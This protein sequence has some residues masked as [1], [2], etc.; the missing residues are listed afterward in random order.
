MRRISNILI[1]AIAAFL[2]ATFL[3]SCSA[4]PGIS[5]P[6]P[7]TSG[8]VSYEQ[9]TSEDNL[10]PALELD[11]TLAYVE[12]NSNRPYFGEENYATPIGT[13]VYSPLDSLGRT[14]QAFAL[15]SQDTM[16]AIA[17]ERGDIS[18]VY[19]SGWCQAQY[20]FVDQGWLYNRCH[21]IGWQLTAEN[22][23]AQNLMSGT[24]FLNIQGMLPFENTVAEHV[25]TT[26]HAVLYRVTPAYIGANLLASGV[27][28]EA[29]CTNCSD[30]RFAVYCP[31]VQPGVTIDYATGES[32]V[33]ESASEAVVDAVTESRPK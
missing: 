24:R 6:L 32:Y 3:S 21:L 23:N 25:R 16:P 2:V 11:S 5:T 28:I 26:A 9:A 29:D 8:D 13:E 31:N 14:G 22:D 10:Y 18:S 7:Q 20:D 15:V 17:E 33:A 19:P 12:I 30:C 1:K 4:T 27:Y